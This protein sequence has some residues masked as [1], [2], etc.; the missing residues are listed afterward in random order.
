MPRPAIDY[1]PRHAQPVTL[2]QLRQLEPE[3]LSNEI[4]RLQHSI[5][6]LERSNDELRR[7]AAGEG[8]GDGEEE[9][10]DDETRREFEE[11]VRENEETIASQKERQHMLR[12]ALEEQ[13]G[14]DARNPHYTPASAPSSAASF[15]PPPVPA[16]TA[17]GPRPPP[18]DE[19]VVDSARPRG[20]EAPP[21]AAGGEEDGGMYL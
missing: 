10:L 1:T 13:V 4:A 21:A 14:V 2:S 16:P 5:Q 18:E 19:E 6:H 7:F 8:D 15:V 20:D 11:S 12:I 17:G 3:L 9:E